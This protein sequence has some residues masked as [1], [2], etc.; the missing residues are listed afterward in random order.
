LTMLR[1]NEMKIRALQRIVSDNS[2]REN[3]Q[4]LK[5]LQDPND[6]TANADR[7]KVRFLEG[8]G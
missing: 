8:S 3:M 1:K 6:G 7:A 5:R 2:Y 4:R